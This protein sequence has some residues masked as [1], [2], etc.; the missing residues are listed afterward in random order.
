MPTTINLLLC[1]L[2]VAAAAGG[3][4]PNDFGTVIA[5]H[6]NPHWRC[7]SE[8]PNCKS[9]ATKA[10]SNLLLN[11]EAP[12]LAND[13]VAQTDFASII[14]FEAPDYRPPPGFASI[15][16]FQSCAHDWATLFY[17]A[18]RWTP[19][20]NTSGCLTA[21]RAFSAAV[22]KT[23]S[24]S[25]APNLTVVS[26]HFP[27]TQHNA[28]AYNEAVMALR[29]VLK[30]FGAVSAIVM[31]DTNTEG[32]AAAA[33]PGHGGFN[34]TNKQ[35]LLDLGLWTSESEPPAA[36]LYKGCCCT[37]DADVP[38]DMP[39][40]WEGDRIVS[41]AGRVLRSTVMFDPAPQWACND[42]LRNTTK[43][44]FHKGVRV[45]FEGFQRFD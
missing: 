36:P 30:Q 25:H 19:I 16:A 43:S 41:N 7:F 29:K 27:Q 22:F 2:A 13:D 10:L 39:F 6:W 42:V 21:G 8:E 11:G 20:V 45:R 4:T 23:A 26:A 17:D 15:G 34:R 37:P 32:P 18:D 12:P 28:S 33:A 14:E 9:N 38:G 3:R 31:A 40:S 1:A 35:L 24:L 44:E 5:A